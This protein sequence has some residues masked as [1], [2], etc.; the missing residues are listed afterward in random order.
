MAFTLVTQ[1]VGRFKDRLDTPP[2][3]EHRDVDAEAHFTVTSDPMPPA[4]RVTRLL[5]EYEGYT[6]QG[7]V[8]AET[9]WSASKTS[10]VLSTMEQEGT[11]VRRQVGRRKAVFLPGHVPA[12][13]E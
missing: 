3:D 8:R 6:W 10:R 13:V 7:H 12:C 5:S 1:L 2:M 9:G 4:E 11:V